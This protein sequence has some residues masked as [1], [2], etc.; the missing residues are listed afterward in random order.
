VNFSTD[1]N[2]LG[3]GAYHFRAV[4]NN[5]AGTTRGNDQTFQTVPCPRADQNGDSKVDVNDV[6]YLVNYLFS[7]GPAPVDLAAADAN[8]DGKLDVQDVFFTVN[9]LFAGGPAPQ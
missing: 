3:C 5:S 4:A 6:F 8:N 9:F 7:G 2:G 1:A